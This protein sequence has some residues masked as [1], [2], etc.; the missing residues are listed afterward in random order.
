MRVFKRLNVIYKSFKKIIRL[1]NKIW[2]N[3]SL[4][5]RKAFNIWNQ[6]LSVKEINHWGGE[7]GDPHQDPLWGSSPFCTLVTA[8]PSPSPT[9]AP[10]L[11]NVAS[12]P[13]SKLFNFLCFVSSLKIL[14]VFVSFFFSKNGFLFFGGSIFEKTL[15]KKTRNFFA[16]V[17]FFQNF[18]K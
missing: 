10:P 13:S 5:F 15:N 2:R 12:P 4:P 1:W 6:V 7:G 17:H 11:S 16:F 8:A 18:E 3:Q 9:L 14:F